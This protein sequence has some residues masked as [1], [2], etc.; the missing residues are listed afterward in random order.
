M[1]YQ[2]DKLLVSSDRCAKRET[3][4]SGVR[5]VRPEFHFIKL[6]ADFDKMDVEKVSGRPKIPERQPYNSTKSS[7]EV[8]VS[9]RSVH[10]HML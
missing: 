10:D 2:S 3:Y 1:N 5:L 4:Q 8:C 9:M 6:K 7:Q